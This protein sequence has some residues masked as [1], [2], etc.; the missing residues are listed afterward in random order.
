MSKLRGLSEPKYDQ[1]FG[2]LNAT[3][4]VSRI[5]WSL[6]RLK[7]LGAPPPANCR[8]YRARETILDVS[9]KP[10]LVRRSKGSEGY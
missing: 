6:T 9:R 7:T 8:L 2:P 10:E 5:D 3:E 1:L 4:M